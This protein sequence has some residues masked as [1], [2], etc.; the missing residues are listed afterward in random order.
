MFVY[1]LP[2]PGN[3]VQFAIKHLR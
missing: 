1:V 2:A 3:S